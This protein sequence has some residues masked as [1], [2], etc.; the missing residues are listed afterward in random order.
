VILPVA[1]AIDDSNLRLWL[2]RHALLFL[3]A[4]DPARNVAIL[5]GLIVALCVLSVTAMLSAGM[6][7]G[8]YPPYM[9]WGKTVSDW[10]WRRCSSMCA[11]AARRYRSS[12]AQRNLQP[13]ESRTACSGCRII[14]I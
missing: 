3:A 7:G 8:F 11:P 12:C 6:L 10:R 5:D 1:V 4:R 9:I 14:G 13:S 2:E